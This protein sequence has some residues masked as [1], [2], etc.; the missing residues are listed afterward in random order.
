MTMQGQYILMTREEFKNWLFNHVFNR[1][2]K[3]ILQHH[4]YDPSYKD[5]DYTNHFEN[6]KGMEDHHVNEM[7]WSTIAQN[8]TTFPDGK[9]AV[10]RP[11]NIAPQ[12]TF[13]PDGS[14]G[15]ETLRVGIS[16]E[17]L[18]DFN[19]GFDVMT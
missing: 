11:F 1:E 16:I 3:T 10:C 8:L 13:G 15:A 6:L 7:G 17:N 18:G 2:I 19:T 9:V 4:T 14:P 5:F 12:G